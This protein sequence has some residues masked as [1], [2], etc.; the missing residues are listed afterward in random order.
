MNKTVN[1]SSDYIICF[2][3]PTLILINWSPHYTST[4]SELNERYEP[5]YRAYRH[6]G[7]SAQIM[8]GIL[9]Y[10]TPTDIHLISEFPFIQL[11]RYG[12]DVVL[13][14]HV[15]IGLNS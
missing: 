3:H 13:S 2:S 6:G 9:I 11:R 12:I 1:P 15:N 4:L 5:I 14:E 8:Y 7:C 10:P